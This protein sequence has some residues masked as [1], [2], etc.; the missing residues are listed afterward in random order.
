VPAFCQRRD[1]VNAGISSTQE[2]CQ[3]G[4]FYKAGFCHC[5][6]FDDMEIMLMPIIYVGANILALPIFCLSLGLKVIFIINDCVCEYH[7]Y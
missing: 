2:F 6:N 3:R 4:N 5:G 1:F 7:N